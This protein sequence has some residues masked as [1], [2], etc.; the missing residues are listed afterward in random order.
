MYSLR[1]AQDTINAASPKGYS[2]G[3]ASLSTPSSARS[4]AEPDSPFDSAR[5]WLAEQE[6]NCSKDEDILEQSY[7]QEMHVTRS[8]RSVGV[9]AIPSLRSESASSSRSERYV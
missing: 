2:S 3:A 6:A 7:L 1:A 8:S 5:S 4:D 9:F